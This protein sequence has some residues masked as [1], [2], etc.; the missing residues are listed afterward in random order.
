MVDIAESQLILISD[1]KPHPR[2]YRDH[3]EDQIEHLMQSIREHGIYKN[4]VTARELTILA[5]HGLVEAAAKME[6]EAVPAVVK[7]I[8]PYDPLALKLLAA[9]NFLPYFAEDDDRALTELLKEIADVDTL[10]GTGFDEQMLAALAMVTRPAEEI[11][12]IDAAAE[13]LGMPEFESD[14]TRISLVLHFD[15]EDMRTEL[16]RDMGLTITNKVRKAW[17]AKYPPQPKDDVRSVM[18]EG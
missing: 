3:P 12:D 2:N 11:E 7:D 17:S 10:F 18:F 13:W 1:L 5:G 14:P 6:I 9:D 15:N 4:I 8:D 16:I